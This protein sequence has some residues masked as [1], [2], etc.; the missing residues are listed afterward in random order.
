[1]H[2]LVI[3]DDPLAFEQD[4]QASVPEARA[5]CRVGL[6]AGEDRR[7]QGGRPSFVSPGGGAEA[8]DSAGTPQARAARLQPPYR[9]APSD[10]AH[11]FF[12]TT[13]FRAWMSSV[14]S[15]TIC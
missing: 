10:R 8:H 3:D 13:A 11:H 6:Q 14:C 2:S 15:A 5:D 12:A 7:V 4:V 1:M 9:L